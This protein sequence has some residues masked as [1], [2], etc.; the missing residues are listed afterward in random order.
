[1]SQC[2][3]SKYSP[4]LLVKTMRAARIK[5][6]FQMSGGNHIKQGRLVYC[7]VWLG[8]P[9]PHFGIYKISS[10]RVEPQIQSYISGHACPPACQHRMRRG[11]GV[12]LAFPQRLFR[13]GGRLVL[14]DREP[15]GWTGGPHE[16]PG[17]LGKGLA[18][19]PVLELQSG[20]SYAR[21]SCSSP[22]SSPPSSK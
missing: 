1:M 17:T 15:C 3:H 7:C 8:P 21:A 16:G 13:V 18:L 5:P 2:K 4:W 19:M 10:G 9:A 11:G 14:L 22:S 6:S 12:C 20:D